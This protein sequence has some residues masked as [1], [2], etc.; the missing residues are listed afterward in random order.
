MSVCFHVT[1]LGFQAA[2]Q[3]TIKLFRLPEII[4]GADFNIR[5]F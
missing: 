1:S 3:Y 5:P 4:V 2:F